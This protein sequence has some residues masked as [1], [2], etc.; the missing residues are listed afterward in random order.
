MKAVVA[1]LYNDWSLTNAD[2]DAFLRG[3]KA[4]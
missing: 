2:I 1:N 3:A 4:S